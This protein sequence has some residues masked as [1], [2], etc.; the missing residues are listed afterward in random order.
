MD[1]GISYTIYSI[2]YTGMKGCLSIDISINPFIYLS[3]VQGEREEVLK[4]GIGIISDGRD[5]M[6]E[7]G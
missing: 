1:F 2:P 7:T 4:F 5:E 3:Q 6:R